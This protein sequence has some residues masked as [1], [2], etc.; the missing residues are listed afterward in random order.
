M[1]DDGDTEEYTWAWDEAED[2]LNGLTAD[3]VYFGST[4]GGDWG[5]WPV[6]D[7]EAQA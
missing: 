5:L 7:D 6:E 2:F 4:E 3:S 1:H